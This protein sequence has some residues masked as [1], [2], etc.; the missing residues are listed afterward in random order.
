[1]DV[2]HKS[3][4]KS[5]SAIRV[6]LVETSHPGNIGSAARA[7]KTMGLT[8]LYL[9]NPR[10]Y[11]SAE[12]TALASGADDVLSAAR[13]C[14]S[15]EDA[16]EDCSVCYGVSARQR[17]LPLPQL[18]PRVAAEKMVAESR[19]GEHVAVIFGPERVGLSNSALD[20]CHSLV[21]IPANPDYTSLNLSMAVQI[22]VYEIYQYQYG[23]SMSD[24][25]T[26]GCPTSLATARDMDLFYKHLEEVLVQTDFLDPASPKFL[27]RRCK[28]MFNRMRPDQNEMNILRGFLTAIQKTIDIRNH[29]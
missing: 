17:R 25:T 4:S 6:V 11:P 10:G 20:L 5:L 13:V 8:Q 23:K 21:T 27:L 28:R 18:V 12:A 3:V 16:L 29:V 15:L 14:D 1:M 24:S 19:R 7:M 9:V 26:E 22:I 2:L